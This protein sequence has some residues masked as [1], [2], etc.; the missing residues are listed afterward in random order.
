LPTHWSCRSCWPTTHIW[1][2]VARSSIQDNS[3]TICLFVCWIVCLFDCV[4]YLHALKCIFWFFFLPYCLAFVPLGA[5]FMMN[6]L[7]QHCL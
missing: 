6:L 3:L 4:C 5:M 1:C 7:H 2:S